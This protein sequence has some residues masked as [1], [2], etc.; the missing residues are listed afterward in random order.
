MAQRLRPS[1]I[2]AAINS[3]GTTFTAITDRAVS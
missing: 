2:S 1:M 3:S